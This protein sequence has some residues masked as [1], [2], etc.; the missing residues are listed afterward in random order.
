MKKALMILMI[1]AVFSLIGVSAMVYA[2]DATVPV[3]EP[4]LTD[5]LE[6]PVVV[7]TQSAALER[8]AQAKTLGITPGKL[9]LIQ[10]LSLSTETLALSDPAITTV[11]PFVI[12]DWTSVSV[13]DIMAAIKS[14]RKAANLPDETLVSDV[15]EVTETAATIEA[16]ITAAV[17]TADT[18]SKSSAK[19]HG[20]AKSNGG[21]KK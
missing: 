13:K 21:K 20:K 14:N 6:I 19:S 4:V 2:E 9:K 3:N 11:S 15:P 16:P 18:S 12:A 8:I 17:R 10:K 1:T 5:V 7:T